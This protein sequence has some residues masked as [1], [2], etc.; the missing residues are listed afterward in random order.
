MKVSILPLKSFISN[1]EKW[2]AISV[3]FVVVVGL[4]FAVAASDGTIDFSTET[5][6]VVPAY[7]GGAY[8]MACLNDYCPG[9]SDGDY[10]GPFYV[11]AADGDR[12]F[13]WCSQAS[14]AVSASVFNTYSEVTIDGRISYL[15]WRYDKDLFDAGGT[16]N[17]E[18]AAVQALVWAWIS[19][20]R[21][22]PDVFDGTDPLEWD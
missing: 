3:L 7:V 21:Y 17:Y 1:F 22:D 9:S 15:T 11:E 18:L 8:V 10:I 4:S 12:M 19:D 6:Q 14:A 20:A 13:A 16:V 5:A 2:G